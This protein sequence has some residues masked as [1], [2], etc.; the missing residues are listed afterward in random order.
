VT[1]CSALRQTYRDRLRAK[2]G[3]PVHLILLE[4][5]RAR[6]IERLAARS[7][8]FMPVSLVDSQLA[9]LERPRAHE[10]ALTLVTE[11][12]ATVLRDLILSRLKDRARDMNQSS[13]SS[14]P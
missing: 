2:I 12:S 1:A 11:Q 5:S 9:T 4:N 3:H 6:L 7:G 14:R 13:E 10:D 8:H